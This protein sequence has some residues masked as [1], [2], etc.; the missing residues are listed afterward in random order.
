MWA[1]QGAEQC[2]I[3]IR[4][5]KKSS[6]VLLESRLSQ[7]KYSSNK[8][9]TKGLVSIRSSEIGPGHD[10][11]MPGLGCSIFHL[12]SDPETGAAHRAFCT[13]SFD[14]FKE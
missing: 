14:G 11:M 12:Y 8:Q 1:I 3:G 10:T 9:K 2:K 13:E 7:E 4:I 6:Q 5:C